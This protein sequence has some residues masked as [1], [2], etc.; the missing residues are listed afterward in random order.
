M[1]NQ[2]ADVQIVLEE[3]RRQ[4]DVGLR[5]GEL[6]DQKAGAEVR[7]PPAQGTFKPAPREG[8]SAIQPGL[9]DG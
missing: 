5:T 8:P 7:M 3:M 2:N 6:L 4:F 9:L 1:E